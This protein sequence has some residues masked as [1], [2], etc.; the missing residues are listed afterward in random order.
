MHERMIEF[1]G[2]NGYVC[3]MRLSQIKCLFPD[4]FQI[5]TSSDWILE[6]LKEDW[7]KVERAFRSAY[8]GNEVRAV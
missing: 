7:P 8:L 1:R 3:L 5:M 6:V 2:S 4:H